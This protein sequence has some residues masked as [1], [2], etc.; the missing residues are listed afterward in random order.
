MGLGGGGGSSEYFIIMK[1][2][3]WCFWSMDGYLDELELWANLVR[4]Y[5]EQKQS[6]VRLENHSCAVFCF[7]FLDSLGTV[8][9]GI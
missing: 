3:K 2:C 9:L 1:L 6:R 4:Y 5:S 7:N 8:L